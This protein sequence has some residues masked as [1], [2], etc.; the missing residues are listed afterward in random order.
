M[1]PHFKEWLIARWHGILDYG[2]KPKASVVA[3]RAVAKIKRDKAAVKWWARKHERDA[4]RKA[5]KESRKGDAMI[6]RE[7]QEREESEL[8]NRTVVSPNEISRQSR[9]KSP[10][11]AKQTAYL[12]YM[13]YGKRVDNMTK[14]E[15]MALIEKLMEANQEK[16]YEIPNELRVLGHTSERM[17]FW[18]VDRMRFYPELYIPELIS[19]L[20]SEMATY[21]RGRFTGSS[22]RITVVKICEVLGLILNE[23]PR[24]WRNTDRKRLF[25]ARF[26]EHYG[27]AQK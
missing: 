8:A 3:A 12:T 13:G 17:G 10:I 11:T 7:S 23:D 21:V 2:N 24:W 26:R 18:P 19:E 6:L 15:A 20:H 1:N 5:L 14:T 22:E 16:G 27:S 4:K 9:S 25:L